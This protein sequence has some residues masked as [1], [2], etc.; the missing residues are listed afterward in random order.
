[1]LSIKNVSF[2]KI[3][4]I[5]IFFGV[6]ILYFFINI[7]IKSCTSVDCLFGVKLSFYDPFSIALPFLLTVLGVFLV[8]PSHYFRRWLWYVA[9]WAFP[10]LLYIIA[11]ESV[12]TSNIQS[13]PDFIAQMGMIILTGITGLFILGVFGYSLFKKYFQ[14]NKK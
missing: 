3:L 7:K 1:M 13:G 11:S 4:N 6:L 12:Y 9:S 14:K 8:I 10:V 5:V 2:Y